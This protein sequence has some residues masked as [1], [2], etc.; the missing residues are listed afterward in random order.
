MFL[1]A[2]TSKLKILVS[3]GMSSG[4]L[5]R[6]ESFWIFETFKSKILTSKGYLSGRLDAKKFDL[7]DPSMLKYSI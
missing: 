2:Q 3:R 1:D 4:F 5:K 7:D 6:N